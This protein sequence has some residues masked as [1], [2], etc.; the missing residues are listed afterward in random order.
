FAKEIL[1]QTKQAKVVLTGR[2]AL[3]ADKQA[4]MAALP[5]PANRV[6]YR[7]VNLTDLNEVKQLIA[8]IKEEH[9]RL[10]GILHSAGMIADNFILKKTSAEFSKVLA[11]K[12]AGTH[13]LDR[14]TQDVD[15]DFFVLFSSIAGA[16]GNVGQAD[17]AT[18]NGFMDQ[19][20]AYRNGQVA[21]GQRHGRTRS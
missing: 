3:D 14:A 7:Q 9:G 10:N 2:S 8:S 17:Y 6:S 4:R 12:V 21:S 18:A 19:F 16:V 5:A 11:P 1:E 13:N 20:A 15:L